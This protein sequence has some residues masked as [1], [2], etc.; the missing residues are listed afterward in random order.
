[1]CFK[2]IFPLKF[3]III[4]YITYLYCMGLSLMQFPSNKYFTTGAIYQT[5]SLI[6]AANY[7]TNFIFAFLEK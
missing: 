7:N 1:M 2:P 5:L 6:T 4:Y 3:P